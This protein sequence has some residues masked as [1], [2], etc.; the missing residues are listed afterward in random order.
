MWARAPQ[1]L[2]KQRAMVETHKHAYDDAITELERVRASHD[3]A[4][5]SKSNGTHGGDG[6]DGDD[7]LRVGKLTLELE[8]A[9]AEAALKQTALERTQEDVA[10]QLEAIARMHEHELARKDDEL[11]KALAAAA[12][13]SSSHA[14]AEDKEEELT[15]LHE[16]HRAKMADVERDHKLRVEALEK[17]LARVERELLRVCALSLLCDTLSW[18]DECVCV[19]STAALKTRNPPL[20][21]R[22]NGLCLPCVSVRALC[23]AAPRKVLG[24][25]NH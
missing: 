18:T 6:G 5:H 4:A 11:A 7:E 13:K 8:E 12:I 24:K 21:K 14:G 17:E 19:C 23:S 20:Y 22:S 1:E 3:N 25:V 2:E 10:Q 16:A 15:Q 9:R